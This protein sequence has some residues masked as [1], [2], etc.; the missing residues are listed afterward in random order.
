MTGKHIK[1]PTLIFALLALAACGNMN[2][3]VTSFEANSQGSPYGQQVASEPAQQADLGSNGYYGYE[4]AM[5]TYEEVVQ[6]AIAPVKEKK[7]ANAAKPVAP[8]GVLAPTKA[9]SA[10][11]EAE[12]VK[13]TEE[14]T[15][16]KSSQ[17][18]EEKTEPKAEPKK[19]EPALSK[20]P[21]A[22][23]SEIV[24]P[25]V[26]KPTVY[27]F[28]ILDEDKNGCKAD[29]KRTLFGAGSKPLL[30]VCPKTAAACALQGSCGIVQKGKMHTFNIIGRF[31]GQDRYFE[32]PDD[33]CRFGYGVNSSCLDPFYTLAAD[34]TIYKPGEVIF[35]PA[36]VGLEL[37]DGSKHNGYFVIRDKGRG[38]KGL[39]RFDFFSGHYSWNDSEN[40]FKKIGLGDVNTNIPYYRIKGE[41]ARKV[42]ASR[43][44]P[45]LPPHAVTE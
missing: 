19:E 16:E 44:F 4:E 7:D 24:G 1:I 35:V 3:G 41:A 28:V 25:G 13:E 22:P 31:D 30:K 39:G 17:V 33:G 18:A 9:S 14:K 21:N 37:P 23:R 15:P 26:L 10:K 12:P 11:A 34:L 32:I 20:V 45:S 29:T 27:F 40:P 43:S 38:I 36:V 5:D 8:V 2:V 6:E 42:Q